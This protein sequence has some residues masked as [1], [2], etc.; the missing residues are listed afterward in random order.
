MVQVLLY[1][2]LQCRT[3]C[4]KVACSLACFQNEQNNNIILRKSNLNCIPH[5]Q[6][7]LLLSWEH[8]FTHGLFVTKHHMH[9][10]DYYWFGNRRNKTNE[11]WRHRGKNFDLIE[12]KK[13][14]K[15]IFFQIFRYISWF[16]IKC[17]VRWHRKSQT[18][19]ILIRNFF[20]VT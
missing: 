10:C 16:S 17:W 3:F 1:Y 4:S 7:C 9:V 13:E 8:V 5:F 15:A 14:K 2:K 18:N 11:I 20:W 19:I 12:E 6:H